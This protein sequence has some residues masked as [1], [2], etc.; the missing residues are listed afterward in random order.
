MSEL[1]AVVYVSWGYWVADCPFPDCGAGQHYGADA[2]TGIVGGL[3]LSS[4]TCPHCG[5]FCAA[6]WPAEAE[7]IWR[8]LSVRPLKKTRNWFPGEDLGN[9]IVENITHGLVDVDELTP[10]PL[11][12]HGRL[13]HRGLALAATPAPRFAITGGRP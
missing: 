4:F 12:D 9:L 2:N 8:L 3:T 7:D 13:T 5:T 11:V 6:D 10:G 1:R